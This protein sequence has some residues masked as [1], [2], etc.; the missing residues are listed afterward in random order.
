MKK[1]K[2]GVSYFELLKKFFKVRLNN[3]IV[4]SSILI[5]CGIYFYFA[6]FGR[7]VIFP[8]KNSA[9]FEFYNDNGN[10]GNSEILYQSISDSTIDLEFIL[11]EGFDSPYV[12]INIT[13]KN[14]S[15]FHI[16]PYNQLSFDISGN[17][18]RSIGFSLYAGNIF[19]ESNEEV[20]FYE[21]ID[22]NNERKQYVVDLKDLKIP[23]WWYGSHNIPTDESMEPDLQHIYRINFGTAF[24]S[25]AD[26][27]RSLRI[28]SIYFD[29]DNS[30]LM[31]FLIGAEILLILILLV[32]DYFKAYK[33]LP[34][35]IT[36]KAVDVEK[37]KNQLNSFLEY[38]NNN[39]HNPELTL[40]QVSEKTGI[41]QRRITSSI[42]KSFGCN[43]KTYI[44]KLRINESKR[45]LTETELYMGEIA[46]KVGFSNQTHF[47]RVFKNFENI[48]PSEYRDSAYQ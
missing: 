12:G 41:N 36:Y 19:S 40:K 44:N 43:F 48:S 45:L 24:G 47:N 27:E 9:D 31:M 8:G 4:I 21:N 46:Y 20:C 29:R 18:V 7:E 37:E 11:R 15:V 30:G 35:T 25:A 3:W 34:V 5:G 2:N 17:Q 22:I 28:Y 13:N 14:D 42:Q 16:S 32:K 33:S 10:G 38:I 6:S 39:F 26:V 1:H 23:D